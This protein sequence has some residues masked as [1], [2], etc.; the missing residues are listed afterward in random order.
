MG[1]LK[2]LRRF[3]RKWSMLRESLFFCCFC[4]LLILASFGRFTTKPPLR[5]LPLGD[6]YT[7]GTGA[8]EAES[9]P[10]LLSEDLN[11]AGIACQL[12]DNPARNGYT[13]SDLIEQEL[14]LVEQLKPDFVT[15]LIGVNDWVRGVPKERF[16]LNLAHILNVL[17]RQLKQKERV[18]L[19]TIPD[20]GVTPQ[21]PVYARGRDISKGIEEFNAI[22]RGE[23]QQRGLKVVELFELS[24]AMGSNRTLVAADGLHPSA[25]E[26]RLWATHILPAARQLLK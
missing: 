20:F 22:I 16:A 14:P 2:P 18:L 19:L 5:F 26:Y 7:I 25:A 3:F 15:V 10:V 12:S 21:G 4:F 8:A 17:Q 9:W 1:Q 11:A 24:R 23:A 6:S 13:T